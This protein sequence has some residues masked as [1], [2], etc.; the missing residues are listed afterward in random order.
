MADVDSRMFCRRVISSVGRRQY[1]GSE[2]ESSI[3]D[4]VSQFHS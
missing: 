2:M 3:T 4:S 1:L